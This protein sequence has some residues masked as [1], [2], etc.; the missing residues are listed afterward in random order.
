MAILLAVGVWF[1]PSSEDFRADNPFWNGMVAFAKD[2]D[3]S[4]LGSLEEL[5]GAPEG[6]VLVL[7]PYLSFSE[8]ELERLEQY[9]S[10]G[11][12]LILLDDY[13]YGN[14][15]LDYLGVRA[16]FAGAPLLD[17][18]FNYKNQW[19]PR[20]TDFAPVPATEGVESLM[21]NHATSLADISEAEVL[22]WSSPF[23]FA[24]LDR[25]TIRDEGE[26]MGPFTVA[27][28]VAAGR[29]RLV[30]VS[31][32]SILINC[33]GDKDDNLTF[34]S[35]LLHVRSPDAEVLV[36]QSHVPQAALDEA[37]GTLA[38]V[39]SALASPFAAL[40]VVAA[41]LVVTLSPIWRRKRRQP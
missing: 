13:G 24:D 10:A 8:P 38:T 16:R 4:P 36:D 33:M 25:S 41:L 32:P 9:V 17:P 37:K 5:P 35:N 14:E 3:A 11:G 28:E 30:L 20:V 15:V 19:L 22:A 23:S 12:D 31:D 40:S 1:Y 39:R 18:L 7:V 29:G 6:S 2:F 26:P 27:A 34:I 21:L